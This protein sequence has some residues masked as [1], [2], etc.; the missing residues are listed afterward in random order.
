M[1]FK[2]LLEKLSYDEALDLFELENGYTADDVNRKYK[3]L[4]MKF[5]PDRGGSVEQMQD[6]NDA[7]E[8]LL[9][10]S[11]TGFSRSK[12][13]EESFRK[14]QEEWSKKKYEIEELMLEITTKY[15]ENFDPEVFRNYFNFVF[16]S[17]FD[18]KVEYNRFFDDCHKF[19]DS[20]RIHAYFENPDRT[21][22]ISFCIDINYY[23]LFDMLRDGTSLSSDDMQVSYWSELFIDGKKQKVSQTIFSQ[24]NKKAIL[25]DPEIMFPM[26]KMEKIAAGEK[27]KG[28][29]LKKRDFESLF[30]LK[31]KG[32]RED[33]NYWIPVC[34]TADTETKV[35]ICIQRYT[36]LGVSQYG[37]MPCLSFWF[38]EG[39]PK[40]ADKIKDEFID[41]VAR[42][43]RSKDYRLGY[44][45]ET[46]ATLNFFDELINA[47]S[48]ADLEDL[49][50]T[51]KP[52]LDKLP[53]VCEQSGME[54]EQDT[55]KKPKRSRF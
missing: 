21:K 52:I 45:Y 37:L 17:N 1:R 29:V 13:K 35:Y 55:S 6:L 48:K 19:S 54:I 26:K 51:A 50:K 53:E 23:R 27:R 20:P 16:K 10:T 42:S 40:N 32:H 9:R 39:K 15:F 47:L 14:A 24:S 46:Q 18:V 28:V 41:T 36:F 43:P 38:P 33:K 44:M 3:R 30:I 34:G 5:H 8:T 4:A 22:I 31:Y 12:S 2:L 25:T 49:S 11:G 7:R